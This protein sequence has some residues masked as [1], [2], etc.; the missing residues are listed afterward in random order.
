MLARHAMAS[1]VCGALVCGCRGDLLAKAEL[2]GEGVAQAR[3]ASGPDALALW[4]QV[5]GKWRGGKLDKLPVAWDVEVTQQ[6]TLVERL[7]CDTDHVESVICGVHAFVD[8]VHEADCELRLSC[9]MPALAPGEVVLDVTGR[10]LRPAQI[11]AI[12]EM[13]LHVR[14]D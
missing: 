5:E 14:A 8:G 3:I 1:L 7:A 11:L 6:G 12:T 9:R 13:S 2:H 4:G 10:M